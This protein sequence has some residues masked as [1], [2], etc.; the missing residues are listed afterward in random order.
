MF[1]VWEY[2]SVGGGVGFLLDDGARSAVR[3]RGKEEETDDVRENEYTTR[4]PPSDLVASL[5]Y[6]E[7][8]A[9]NHIAPLDLYRMNPGP[10]S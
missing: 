7:L 1:V 10:R 9:L 3:G 2:S 6:V 4:L 8:P 5:P